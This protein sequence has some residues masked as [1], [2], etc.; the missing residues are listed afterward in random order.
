MTYLM[1]RPDSPE[2]P[3][4]IFSMSFIRQTWIEAVV[5][6]IQMNLKKNISNWK[7]LDLNNLTDVIAPQTNIFIYVLM[8]ERS[9]NI[10]L[11]IGFK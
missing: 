11:C 2:L 5:I 8:V 10:V 1:D 9:E 6:Q 3:T 4:E 7:L